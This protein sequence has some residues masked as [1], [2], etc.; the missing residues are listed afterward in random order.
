MSQADS[1][2]QLLDSLQTAGKILLTY[3]QSI[4]PHGIARID[5]FEPAAF[6]RCTKEL[7][8]VN[9]LSPCPDFSTLKS[10]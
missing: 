7:L 10:I 8:A 1:L 4:Q 3:D 9:T 5:V 2:V 6:R